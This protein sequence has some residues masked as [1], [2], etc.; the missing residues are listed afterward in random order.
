MWHAGVDSRGGAIIA[1]DNKKMYVTACPTRTEWFERFMQ[2]N[3]A[4]TGVIKR[5]NFGM[6]G[7]ALHAALEMLEMDWRVT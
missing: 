6:S 5:R 4:R 3:K 7:T 1:R 2:G